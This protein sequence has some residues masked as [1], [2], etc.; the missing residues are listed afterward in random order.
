M[1]YSAVDRMP[2]GCCYRRLVPEAQT[3]GFDDFWR[4]RCASQNPAHWFDGGARLGLPAGRT[5]TAQPFPAKLVK[6][7]VPQAPGG[8]T[9][10][11]ARKIGQ[12]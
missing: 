6:L 12:A 1:Q 8:A 11:F 5:A 7:V 2:P 10:V 3:T 9:D 4:K